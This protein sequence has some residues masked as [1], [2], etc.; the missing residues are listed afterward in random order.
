MTQPTEG[1]GASTVGPAGVFASARDRVSAVR[2]QARPGSWR[3]GAA[4]FVLTVLV[5]WVLGAQQTAFDYQLSQ[6]N[7]LVHGHLDMTAEYT[8]NLHLLERVLYDGEGFC[9]PLDDPRGEQA[10]ALIENP[11]FSADCRHYMQHSLGPA[12]ILVPLALVWGLEV[13]QNMISVLMGGLTTLLVWAITGRFTAH[14]AT[15]VGLTVLAMFGTTLWYSAA[16][17]SVWYFAHATAVFF[18]FATIYATVVLRNPLLAGAFVGAAFLCRPT[19]ALAGFFPLVAFADRWYV[20]DAGRAIWQRIRLRPLVDL[21]VGV[22]PFVLIGLAVNWLRFDNPFE[23]GYNYSEEFHQIDLKWRWEYGL[24]HPAY[25][26]RHAEVFWEYMPIFSSAGSYVWPSWGGLAMWFTSPALLLG[27]FVHLRRYTR[28]A[29]AIAAAVG[30]GGAVILF[31]SIVARLELGAWRLSD[32]PLAMH[33]LPFW[34]VVGIALTLAVGARDR[35][36]LA[37]W[38]AIIP[39]ALFNWMFAAT[40]WSQFGYRYGLD[41]MPFLFVLAV[42]AVPRLRWYHALLIAASVAVNLWGVLWIL[43]FAPIELFGWTWVSF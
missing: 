30:V 12:F 36:V 22:A 28:P 16:N 1:M 5:Y 35:L 39:I 31:A 23:S 14:T 18:V 8:R 29:L 9:L 13:N 34:L 3:I 19:T 15:R 7:N 41:F 10:A 43:K 40:G 37:C 2:A 24:L 27:L 11:R 42:M 32:V 26:P 21:A 38:A 33:L 4:L 6:A 25:I 17:G 20:A